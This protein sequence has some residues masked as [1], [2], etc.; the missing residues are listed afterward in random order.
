MTRDG[1]LWRVTLGD[2]HVQLPDAR[3]LELLARLIDHPAQEIHVLVLGSDG[4]EVA[5]DSDAGEVLDARAIESYRARIGALDRRLDDARARSD[6]RNVERFERERELLRAE[7]ARAIGLG[8]R[9][10]QAGS[11]SERARV[12]VQRRLKDGIARIEKLDAEIGR[13]LRAAVRTGTYCTFR[14]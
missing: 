12:N 10:R 2:R 3:G 13:Y 8:G 14:P 5:P 11:T 4:A 6:L 1:A 9:R 7:V